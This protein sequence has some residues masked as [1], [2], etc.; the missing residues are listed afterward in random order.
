[1]FKD[2]GTPIKI[3]EGGLI[4]VKAPSEID[5]ALQEFQ[6]QSE[7]VPAASVSPQNTELEK[8][9]GMVR[10]VMKLSGGA[11][12]TQKVA[13]Y[14]LLAITV[15]FMSI[16]FYLFFGGSNKGSQPLPASLKQMQQVP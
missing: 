9:S 12:K 10:L 5:K 7:S 15:L 16:S 4:P 3:P 6:A 13:E 8:Y 11:I 2:D 14:V 1:M